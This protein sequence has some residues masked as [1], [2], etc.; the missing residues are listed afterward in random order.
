ML[1][2]RQYLKLSWSAQNAF[3]SQSALAG[4]TTAVR[5]DKAR[6]AE[7]IVF[8]III[9]LCCTAAYL[10]RCNGITTVNGITPQRTLA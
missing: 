6:S 5:N 2:S 10:L 4:A 7:S 3:R 8:M 9:L 1:D